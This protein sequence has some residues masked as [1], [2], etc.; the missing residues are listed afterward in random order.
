MKKLIIFCSIFLCGINSWAISSVSLV[1]L[2]TNG[3]VFEGKDVQ[4]FGYFDDSADARLY[5][6]DD[7]ALGGDTV[8]SIPVLLSAGHESEILKCKDGYFFLQ[9]HVEITADGM[10]ILTDIRKIISASDSAICYQK[11]SGESKSSI[12]K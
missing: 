1:E 12:F 5:L 8:S 4:V 11:K 2:L 6:T 3:N 10:M 7:H 9:G